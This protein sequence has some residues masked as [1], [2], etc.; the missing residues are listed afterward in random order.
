MTS[1]L[2][3]IARV[4]P[5]Y[6][7]GAELGRGGMGVVLA[8]R[9]TSLDR[10]VAIKEL[11]AALATDPDI[12]ARFAAE[13]RVLAGLD[14]PHIVPIYDYVEREGMCMLVMESLPGGTV[15]SHFIEQ[16]FAYESACAIAMVTCSGLDYAHSRGV[17]HRDIKPENLL[18]S[19]DG[20]LKVTDFGIAKVLNGPDTKA[21]S[22][23][24]ILG[25]PAYIAPEQAQ[26]AELGPPADVYATAVMLYELLSGQLPYSE[27]GGAMAIVF[28]HVYEDANPIRN[29]APQVP[30]VLEVVVMR[31][32][33]R[34]PAERYPDAEAFGV[35]IGEAASLLWGAG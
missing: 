22:N 1:S 15:W 23:G 31:G 20:A 33:A 29:V 5:Q 32:L 7:I 6:E 17:L 12:R 28:R 10:A 4:L 30:E 11:P 34:D 13:A 26:G 14:H 8:G 25:T 18:F 2:D 9:H 27:E 16:G 35:A 3:D 21:T 24:D 19:G